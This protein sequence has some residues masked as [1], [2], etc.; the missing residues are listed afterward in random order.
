MTEQVNQSVERA[1]KESMGNPD[2]EAL[3][4]IDPESAQS[5]PPSTKRQRLRSH[6]GRRWWVWL[7]GFLVFAV[8]IIIIVYLSHSYFR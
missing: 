8:V 7:A 6:C 1:D 5:G 3:E 2:S 4:K